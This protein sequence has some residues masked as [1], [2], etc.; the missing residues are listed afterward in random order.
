MPQRF[1]GQFK[2]SDQTE[3]F[4]QTWNPDKA[5]ARGIFVI[6]HGFA[7]HSECY[8]PLAK[9]LAEDGWLVYAWDMRGHGRSE[10]KRGYAKNLSFYIDD[11]EVFYNLVAKEAGDKNIVL[12]GH[13]TG[14]LIL[15]RYLETKR[16]KYSALILSSPLIGLSM[17]VPALKEAA[18]RIAVKWM[19][20]LTLYNEIKYEDLTRDEEMRKSYAKDNLRHDKISPGVFLSMLENFPLALQN[21]AEIQQPVLMQLAG[22][23]K[24]T[25]SDA[26]R[27]LFDKL[28]NKKNQLELYPDSYHEVYN[29]L[30]R[31]KA[32]ADLKKFINPYLGA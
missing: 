5:P 27:E 9:I 13:S 19:P 16:V 20:T 11:L 17:K 28:P 2:G 30:D 8:A 31:D 29:D 12:F 6:T 10:G 22:D 23:D 3:L 32:I 21:A 25:S 18:A 14:G 1:E 26:S 24:I 4:F 15:L 7:E